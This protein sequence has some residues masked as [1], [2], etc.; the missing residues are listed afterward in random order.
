M[1]AVEREVG[2]LVM[3]ED[4]FRPAPGFMAAVASIAEFTTMYVMNLMAAYTCLRRVLI[5]LVKVAGVTAC[6]SVAELE[7]EVGFVMIKIGFLPAVSVMATATFLTLFAFV[8]IDLL[9]T[10]ITI[11]RRFGMF[12]LVKVTGI[13]AG[14][15]MRTV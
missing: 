6:I 4:N 12:L 13:T 8:Y 15:L 3:V 2:L 11:I 10:A 14:I 7:R 9:M 5:L 1:L